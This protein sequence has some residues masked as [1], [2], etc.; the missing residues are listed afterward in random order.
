[1]NIHKPNKLRIGVFVLLAILFVSALSIIV[2]ISEGNYKLDF[3]IPVM[4]I[5]LVIYIIVSIMEERGEDKN[6]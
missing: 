5:I 1:M 3:I 6:E 2:R 4:N